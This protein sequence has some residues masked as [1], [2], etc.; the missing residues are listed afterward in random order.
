M[1]LFFKASN[2]AQACGGG[3]AVPR[4]KGRQDRYVHACSRGLSTYMCSFNT[5]LWFGA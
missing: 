5:S 3:G 1:F 2:T 4:P